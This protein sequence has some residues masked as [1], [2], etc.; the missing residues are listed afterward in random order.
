MTATATTPAAKPQPLARLP[1]HAVVIASGG[2][3]S[4]VL[5][6]WLKSLGAQLTLLSADYGQRHRIELHYA[7]LVGAALGAQ[8]QTV[9]LTS[10]GKLLSGSALTDPDVEVPA[11]HY[12]DTSMR[13][14]V[15]PHRSALLLD[16]AIGLAVA[17]GADLVAFG[18]HA[19]D[20]PIYPDCRPEFVDAIRRAVLVANDG[21]L[22]DGFAV[23]A[24]FIAMTKADIVRLGAELSVPFA[25]TWSCY[26][27]HQQHCGTCGTCVER[28]EAFQVAGVEDPTG[29]AE[30]P[31]RGLA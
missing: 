7:A 4:T 13:T 5:A 17:T 29:Y 21:F 12:T 27:G 30:A 31:G 10:V 25:A 11:G 1:R 24:P 23:A 16:V 8:H 18:A 14:T 15:V 28:A 22:T 19:G 6:Y 2:L 3:D 9:D 20:H 26:R